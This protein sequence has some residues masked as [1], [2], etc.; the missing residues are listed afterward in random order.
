VDKNK[1]KEEEKKDEEADNEKEKE[2]ENAITLKHLFKFEFNITEG[3][4]VSCVDINQANPDLIA[5]GYGEYDIDCT[6]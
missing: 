4:Q 1:E 3:R 5:V 2:D 6:K